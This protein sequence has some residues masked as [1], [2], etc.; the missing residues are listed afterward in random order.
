L[1]RAFIGDIE[2]IVITHRDR[3]CRFRYELVEFVFSKLNIKIK[4]M[5]PIER[6]GT[7][8]DETQEFSE[9][10][11]SIVTAFVARYRWLSWNGTI[12]TL[13]I[14]QNCTI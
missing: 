5:V 11:I 9:D 10:L 1:E 12:K 6:S 14:F 8:I 3:L 7:E 13:Q 4:V 2:E